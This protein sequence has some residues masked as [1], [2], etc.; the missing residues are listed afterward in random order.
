MPSRGGS[1][2]GGG[3]FLAW[4]LKPMISAETESLGSAFSSSAS[5]SVLDSPESESTFSTFGFL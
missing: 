3:A 4:G 1:S 2:G 5:E